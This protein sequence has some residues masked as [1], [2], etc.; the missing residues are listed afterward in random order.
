[1]EPSH[2]LE[3]K[4]LRRDSEILSLFVIL[5]VL[6]ILFVFGLRWVLSGTDKIQPTQIEAAIK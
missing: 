5:G 1:M 6:T 2:K 4:K 3:Q